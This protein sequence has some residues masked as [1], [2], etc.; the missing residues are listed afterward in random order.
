M[1]KTLVCL[2][3]FVFFSGCA[4]TPV[5]R[6]ALSKTNIAVVKSESWHNVILDVDGNRD[7]DRNRENDSWFALPRLRDQAKLKP[8]EHTLTVIGVSAGSWYTLKFTAEPGH[9][10]LVRDDLKVGGF[11]R[12]LASPLLT[13]PLARIWIVDAQSN[14]PM[15]EVIE[16]WGEPVKGDTVFS[17]LGF[18]SWVPSRTEQRM[19]LFRRRDGL[20]VT[21][22]RPNTRGGFALIPR[23]PDVYFISI[24]VYGLPELKTEDMFADY[25]RKARQ[26]FYSGPIQFRTMRHEEAVELLKGRADFCIKYHHQL[27]SKILRPMIPSPANPIDPELLL[28]RVDSP[29][30]PNALFETFG[31]NCRVPTNQRFGIDF[32]YSHE[33]IGQDKDPAMAEQ[34]DKYFSQLKF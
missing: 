3:A 6:T 7:L 18:F 20:T 27:L 19:V 29:L 15:G 23:S 10:Y 32:E 17:L 34:A 33:S 24:L 30:A 4:H 25:V 2:A 13:P 11:W 14:N 9:L 28:P 8:G 12:F 26:Q 31:F 21:W 22:R 5:D 16:S 1:K